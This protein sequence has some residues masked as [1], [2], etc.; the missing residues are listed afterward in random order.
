MAYNH[1]SLHQKC[2]NSDGIKFVSWTQLII[3]FG[4][5]AVLGEQTEF[6]KITPTATT[7]VY[8]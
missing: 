1:E 3:Y 6:L 7:Q 2:S 5:V 8:R 4:Y